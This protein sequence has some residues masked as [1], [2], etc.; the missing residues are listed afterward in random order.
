MSPVPLEIHDDTLHVMQQAQPGLGG[1][2]IAMQEDVLS[3]M[4][5]GCQDSGVA[6]FEMINKGCRTHYCF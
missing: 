1:F 3:L 6:S 4:S 5:G 2:P